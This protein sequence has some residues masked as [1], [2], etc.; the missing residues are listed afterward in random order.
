MLEDLLGIREARGVLPH[1]GRGMGR[2]YWLGVYDEVS[3]DGLGFWAK[4]RTGK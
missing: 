2:S 4:M 1:G 3:C